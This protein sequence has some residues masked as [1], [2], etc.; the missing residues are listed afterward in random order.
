MSKV[1]ETHSENFYPPG[2]MCSLLPSFLSPSQCLHLFS[3]CRRRFSL[4]KRN[5]LCRF[6]AS[7][8]PAPSALPSLSLSL[9]SRP[10]PIFSSVVTRVTALVVVAFSRGHRRR[11]CTA[12][13]PIVIRTHSPRQCISAPRSG[14][15]SPF[16]RAAACQRRKRKRKGRIA[17][18]LLL[19]PAL[20]V[21]GENLTL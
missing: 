16:K 17:N 1:L 4:P 21:T 5:G 9:L 8:A 13:V 3:A 19:P 15:F 20:A 11:S 12:V 14:L 10:S 7:P 2:I 6:E 18:S